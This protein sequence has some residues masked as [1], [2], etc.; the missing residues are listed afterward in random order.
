MFRFLSILSILI[1]N[2]SCQDTSFHP[3]TIEAAEGADNDGDGRSGAITGSHDMGGAEDGHSDSGDDTGGSTDG[4]D[5]TAG[6]DT[7]GADDGGSDGGPIDF[8]SD[9]FT[10]NP[11][12]ESKIDILW[13]IDNSGSMKN[14][15]EAIADNFNQFIKHFV[16]KNIDFKMNIITTDT[17]NSPGEPD[18]SLD[19][20]LNS[21]FHKQDPQ[22]FFRNFEKAVQVG[23]NGHHQEKGLEGAE[24]FFNKYAHRFFRDK[25]HSAVIYV[26]DEE[27]QSSDSVEFY[28]QNAQSFVRNNSELQMHAIVRS[29]DLEGS[30]GSIQSGGKRYIEAA[31]R[32]NGLNEEINQNFSNTLNKIGENIV[33]NSQNFVLSE[34]PKIDTIEVYVDSILVDRN[35]WTYNSSLNSIEFKSG[36]RPAEGSEIRVKYQTQ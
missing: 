29:K 36:S 33:T 23:I 11:S 10:V 6:D 22:T 1:L 27:D 21:D 20:T 5:D 18:W 30:G 25:S 12:Q 7:A 31:N 35:D 17:L 2:F 9:N 28:V 4:G 13:V 34:I 26:S 8:T 19:D 15:Q 16:S 14:E 3:G 24:L 32:T